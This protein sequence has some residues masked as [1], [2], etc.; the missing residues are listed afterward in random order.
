MNHSYP[1]TDRVIDLLEELGR[2]EGEKAVLIS[3]K[4]APTDR[5]RLTRKIAEIAGEIVK[6]VADHEEVLD[7][8]SRFCRHGRRRVLASRTR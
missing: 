5:G 2:L 6:I 7:A 8:R 3:G 4:Y 1:K